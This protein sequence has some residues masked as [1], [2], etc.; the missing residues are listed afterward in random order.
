MDDVKDFVNKIL[1]LA[2]EEVLRREMVRFNRKRA[3]EL[4]TLEKMVNN[5]IGVY[6]ALR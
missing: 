2:G 6:Q 3:E 5:Y 4:F 1:D